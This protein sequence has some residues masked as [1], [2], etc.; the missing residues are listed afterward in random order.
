MHRCSNSKHTS[1]QPLQIEDFIVYW[2]T[3]LNST[4]GFK[5]HA[6]CH[7]RQK[8]TLCKKI[9]G[10]ALIM[11][12]WNN[13]IPRAAKLIPLYG[14]GQ[15]SVWSHTHTHTHTLTLIHTHTDTARWFKSQ[16]MQWPG[17]LSSADRQATLK[18]STEVIIHKVSNIIVRRNHD[19]IS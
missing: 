17:C 18:T 14:V 6:L 11:Y 7:T 19:P 8:C 1:L 13:N 3:K 12:E 16:K 10:F 4:S 15:I 5:Q 9:T 2:L